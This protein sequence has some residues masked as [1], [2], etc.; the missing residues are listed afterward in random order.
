MPANAS[1]SNCFSRPKGSRKVPGSRWKREGRAEDVL[2]TKLEDLYWEGVKNELE[3]ILRTLERLQNSEGEYFKLWQEMEKSGET[4]SGYETF[5]DQVCPRSRDFARRYDVAQAKQNFLRGYKGRSRA[6]RLKKLTTVLRSGVGR[7]KTNEKKKETR[8]EPRD[9]MEENSDEEVDTDAKSIYLTSETGILDA[10]EAEKDIPRRVR[11]YT[12][13]YPFGNVHMALRV[14]PIVIENGVPK[15][16]QAVKMPQQ[17]RSLA[18]AGQAP[19]NVYSS[20]AEET[21]LAPKRTKA[22][23]KQVVGTPFTG[24]SDQDEEREILKLLVEAS[25]KGWFAHPAYSAMEQRSLL[26]EALSPLLG[27]VKELMESRVQSYLDF[28]SERLLSPDTKL[29]WNRR[30]NNCQNFCDAL[31]SKGPLVSLFPETDTGQP[32]PLYLISFVCRPEA[33]LSKTAKT[34]LDVPHGLTEEYLLKF[35]FGLHEESD[36]IDTLQ[37]YWH[38]FG[39]FGKHLYRFQDMFPWDC[40]EAFSNDSVTCSDC[41]LSKHVWAFPFDSW[42]IISL[43]FRRDRCLYPLDPLSNTDLSDIDWIRTRLTLLKAEEYLTAGAAAM[44]SKHSIR[45]AMQ[46]PLESREPQEDRWRLGGI[47]RAQ[48][49]SHCYE[50]GEY[51]IHFIAEWAHLG[52]EEQVARYELL[53]DYR[54]E[55]P[56]MGVAPPNA[57]LTGSRYESVRPGTFGA[58]LDWVLAFEAQISFTEASFDGPQETCSD[59]PAGANG[60]GE[61]AG[62]DSSGGGARLGSGTQYSTKDTNT[63]ALVSGTDNTDHGG[64]TSESLSGTEAAPMY[65]EGLVEVWRTILRAIEAEE[66]KAVVEDG[67]ITIRPAIAM[68]IETE[69]GMIT[70]PTVVMEVEEKVGMTTPLAIAMGAEV[71]AEEEEEEEEE[72]T[73]RVVIPEVIVAGEVAEAWTG[74]ESRLHTCLP[75]EFI[76]F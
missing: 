24:L 21:G 8:E 28:L 61:P 7:S 56:D 51:R 66:A 9:V 25:T 5:V 17:P 50:G 42:S 67:M 63:D 55:M 26:N 15:F 76:L 73:I 72:A 3:V 48:P 11:R 70:I 46:G 39:G 29:R 27:A 12:R 75:V 18:V 45:Q 36:M 47:H 49:W 71:A 13:R 34:K 22:V 14:G 54:R 4:V 65:L 16:F 57:S 20:S 74:S 30:N 62:C 59:G 19:R 23:L 60:A 33:Y 52:A 64:G 40:T 1:L 6:A 69:V 41:S 44:A 58:R 38:D 68:E 43:H 31:L 2:R 35:H 10:E 53:R 37:E 32:D